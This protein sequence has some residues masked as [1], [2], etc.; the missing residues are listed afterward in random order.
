MLV[1]LRENSVRAGFGSFSRR[2]S[3]AP[4]IWWGS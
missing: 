2:L 1:S 4:R 3:T